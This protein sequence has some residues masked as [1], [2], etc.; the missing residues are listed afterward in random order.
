ME[1]DLPL[2]FY[3]ENVGICWSG[4]ILAPFFQI[5]FLLLPHV[6]NFL[7]DFKLKRHLL[8]TQPFKQ[9]LATLNKEQHL[10]SIADEFAKHA[11]LQRKI[12]SVQDQLIAETQSATTQATWFRTTFHSVA[13]GFLVL[14]LICTIMYHKSTPLLLLPTP[15]FAPVSWMIS[16]PTGIDGAVGFTFW[17]I[18]CR[19]IINSIHNLLTPPK[20]QNEGDTMTSFMTNFMS[21]L[22]GQKVGAQHQ[23]SGGMANAGLF[24]ENSNSQLKR[25]QEALIEPTLD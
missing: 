18:T 8:H 20:P 3:P 2:H 10:I 12:N 19:R 4:L 5:T 11:K 25:R 1:A 24:Q 23:A 16:F 13:Y 6:A 21:S 22:Q 14:C 15:W 7:K 9:Q 17:M